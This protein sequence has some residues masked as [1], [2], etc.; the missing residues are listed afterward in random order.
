MFFLDKKYPLWYFTIGEFSFL[1][2]T[3]FAEGTTT[4]GTATRAFALFLFDDTVY[5]YCDTNYSDNRSGYNCRPIHI[6]TS[7]LLGFIFVFAK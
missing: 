7:F 3:A 6:F 5:D 1:W 2:M 4:A